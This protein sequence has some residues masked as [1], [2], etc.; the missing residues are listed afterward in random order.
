MMTGEPI[1]VEKG[2][3]DAVTG[4]T[5]NVNG[6]LVVLA[7]RVGKDTVLA[8]IVRMVQ[9]AQG[10]KPP[11]GRLADVIASYFVPA[12]MGVAAATFAAWWAF[13]P[14]PRLTYA[15]LATISVLIIACPCALGLA[16]P[17]SIMVGTGRGAE[18]GI[19]VRSGAALETAHK[20]RTVVL[21]KTGTVTRGRPDLVGVRL[22]PNGAFRG[23]EGEREHLRLGAIAETGS[24]HPL[25]DAV[26]RGARGRGIVVPPPEGFSSVPG[27]GIRASTGRFRVH[28]GNAKWLEE[29]GIDPA[30]LL[31]DAGELSE[32]GCTS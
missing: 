30:P 5:M 29:E 1:P 28:A 26:V 31:A 11:I 12:V 32:R 6:R 19:L 10:S 23:E 16:T 2:P 20:V 3:G 8:R 27:H 21:D 17:T 18:L 24:E 7:A 9:E 15:M 13:G 4:G 25:G 22:A 14:E